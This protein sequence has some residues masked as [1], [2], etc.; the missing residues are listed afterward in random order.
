[1]VWQWRYN[2]Y[3]C[4][5]LDRHPWT[6]GE[7]ERSSYVERK[8]DGESL[9]ALWSYLKHLYIYKVESENLWWD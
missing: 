6:R 5:V 7:G 9:H 1:M 8:G 4:H 3:A 2:I